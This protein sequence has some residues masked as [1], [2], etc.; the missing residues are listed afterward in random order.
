MPFPIPLNN[1]QIK[2]LCDKYET[3]LQLYDADLIK[4]NIGK[5]LGA[6]RKYFSNFQ[7]YFAVKALPNPHI[8][9]IIVECGLGLDC[10]SVYEL[11]LAN[12]I[13]CKN[14]FFTGNYLSNSDIIF[15]SKL[16]VILN[17]DDVD[18]IEKM[19]ELHIKG[20]IKQ[21]E[22]ISFRYNPET[23]IESQISSNVL[24]GNNSKFG[25]SKTRIFLAYK[26]AKEFGITKFGIHLMIGSN[27][28]NI[29]YWKYIID[30]IF[31]IIMYIYNELKIKFEF[32]NLGGG[33]GIP[34]KP[35]D[36][37]IN[38]EELATLIY[39]TYNNNINK[40]NFLFKPDIYMENGRYITGPYGWLLTR[41]ISI[42]KDQ[43]KIFC[44]IDANMANLMRPGMY[45]AYHHISVVNPA[46]FMIKHNVVGSLCENN[47]WFCK[48]RELPE[49]QQD[50][51]LIIYDTGAHSH[52]MGFNY[53]GKYKA[54][55]VVLIDG[56]D[57]LI[58][59]RENFEY[60][61]ELYNI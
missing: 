3:P 18:A 49:I 22:I 25:M 9:K 39:N 41:C 59:K 47:D 54:S 17:L 42:K 35:K 12:S 19:I 16:D 55:E 34:Y 38:I 36:A 53:N 52:C 4:N 45:G 23:V 14:I 50:T 56:V 21:P 13:G 57:K 7:Q 28:Q 5:F 48:D 11:Q 32:I 61:T 51:I 40:Y 10:S 27:I 26:K 60:L 58:R 33:I 43:N 8:L 24:C 29:M 44:G 15:A 30:D 37:N 20:K 1:E 31:D 2:L 6:F 46:Q